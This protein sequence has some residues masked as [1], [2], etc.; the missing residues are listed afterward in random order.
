MKSLITVVAVLY[1]NIALVNFTC[2]ILSILSAF[3]F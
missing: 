1:E 3:L 2:I